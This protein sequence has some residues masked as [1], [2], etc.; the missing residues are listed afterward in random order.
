VERTRTRVIRE[1]SCGVWV[2]PQRGFID[3]CT[4]PEALEDLQQSSVEPLD[5]ITLEEAWLEATDDDPD[6]DETPVAV[7]EPETVSI[8]LGI[9]Q[10]LHAMIPLVFEMLPLLPDK[11]L[12]IEK[13]P[14]ETANIYMAA[15]KPKTPQHQEQP[16]DASPA[17][18]KSP[19]QKPSLPY[20]H[21]LLTNIVVFSSPASRT[22]AD[23]W[24]KNPVS[25]LVKGIGRL[26]GL[27]R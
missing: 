13:P 20:K 16:P 11:R 27:F 26:F 19:I 15:Q 4:E 24:P 1:K 6:M 18:Q 2:D 22:D 5:P 7:V 9:A 25:R 21:P 8:P 12:S 14:A 3:S 23:G 10:T 17:L